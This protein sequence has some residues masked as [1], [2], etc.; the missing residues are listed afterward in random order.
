MNKYCDKKTLKFKLVRNSG[1]IM[2]LRMKTH[3]H[4]CTHSFINLVKLSLSFPTLTFTNL[5]Y[6]LF[7]F[8]QF[9]L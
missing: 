2:H 1:N 8:H 5:F 9:V 6:K 4:T 3:I 7:N